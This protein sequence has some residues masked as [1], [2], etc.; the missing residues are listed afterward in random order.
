VHAGAYGFHNYKQRKALT[1]TKKSNKTI[2]ESGSSQQLLPIA[3]TRQPDEN[4]VRKVIAKEK[5]V[6]KC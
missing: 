3:L 1:P 2:G 4:V 6:Y 5:V